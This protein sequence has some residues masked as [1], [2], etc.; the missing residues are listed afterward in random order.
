MSSEA[1]DPS[2]ASYRI[3]SFAFATP[4]TQLPSTGVGANRQAW[5]NG[6]PAAS[7]GGIR[8]NSF[9]SG[10]ELQALPAPGRYGRVG[11]P[12]AGQLEL[13]RRPAVTE[14]ILAKGIRVVPWLI[15]AAMLVAAPAHA[16]SNID[17]GKSPAQIFSNTCNACHR[18]PRELKPTSAG[19]LREHY[20]TGGREAAAMAA[21]LASV[22]SDSRAVLQRRPPVLGA[23]QATAPDSRPAQS[24]GGDQVKPAVKPRR[25]SESAEAGA[26][27]VAA[28]PGGDAES[29]PA[30]AAAPLPRQPA[31]EFEE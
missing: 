19:F 25:P 2:A 1:T 7:D 20:A 16:Q 11:P 13:G 6:D 31:E 9:R 30:Q 18:S 27:P 28:G 24:S 12:Q 17:A 29:A 3:I 26:F 14:A 5:V 23:G 15:G 4:T 10:N 22:G 8:T 21:Y